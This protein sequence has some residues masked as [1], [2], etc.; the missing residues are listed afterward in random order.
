MTFDSI[1]ARVYC[2][3]EIN[4]E[5]S[6]S[7]VKSAL[8]APPSGADTSPTSL[9]TLPSSTSHHTHTLQIQFLQFEDKDWRAERR[10]DRWFAKSAGS[11]TVCLK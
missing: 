8:T 4:P 3:T 9:Y 11:S 10:F 7:R 2:E 5:N 1:A 6:L